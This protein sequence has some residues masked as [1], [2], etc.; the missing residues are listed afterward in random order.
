MAGL[1]R[2][3]ED[4]LKLCDVQAGEK[5]ALYT[6]HRFDEQLMNE[7]MTAL[8]NLDTD[9]L[10]VIEP[11]AAGSKRTA[12]TPLAYELF[13]ALDMAIDVRYLFPWDEDMPRVVSLH[14]PEFKKVRDANPTLRWLSVAL[15]FP[16]INYRRLFPSQAMINRSLAGA[17]VMEKAKEIR[18]TSRNGTD[19]FCRKDGRQGR[20]QI[21]LVNREHTWDNYG[22]GN[23]STTPIEDSAKGVIVVSPGDHWHYPTCPERVNIVREEMRLTFEAGKI[24]KIDGGLEAKLITQ[25]MREADCDNV[26]RIAHIGWGTNEKGVGL[27]NRLYCVADFEGAY[28]NMMIHFGGYGGVGGPHMSGPSVMHHNFYLD[29]KLIVEDGE[30][31]DSR[32]Q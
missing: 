11:V 14:T 15:P 16:E 8:S 32:C 18:V 24:V 4:M 21:G 10:R 27:G 22:C 19:F 3:I 7:Y 2:V 28:G 12:E 26:Y 30:I 9:Y 31:V 5:I 25:A 17:E 6:G 23:V 20:Y 13:K 29:E 1:N